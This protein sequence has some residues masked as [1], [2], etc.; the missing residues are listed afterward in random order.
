MKTNGHHV[1]GAIAGFFC[2]IG[3]TALI[4]PLGTF[5]LGS[6]VVAILPVAVS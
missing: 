4:L 2:L 1:I 5:S 6:I 3:L